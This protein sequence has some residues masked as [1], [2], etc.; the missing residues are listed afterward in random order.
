ME[1]N[2]ES[3]EEDKID[4]DLNIAV[5]SDNDNKTEDD[6]KVKTRT[7]GEA[8]VTAEIVQGPA[9]DKNSVK[10]DDV[11]DSDDMQDDRKKK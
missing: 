6:L 10:H 7:K 3:W 9:F 1:S 2:N 8:E 11:H 5:D 4:V